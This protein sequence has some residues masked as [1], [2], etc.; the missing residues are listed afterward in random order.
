[1]SKYTRLF[2]ENIRSRGPF[3]VP[4]FRAIRCQPT[5][6]YANDRKTARYRY[7]SADIRFETRPRHGSGSL[8]A[9]AGFAV[10]GAQTGTEAYTRAGQPE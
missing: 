7:S 9:T 1:M 2:G 5:S 4:V 8:R 3:N 10:T 6:A